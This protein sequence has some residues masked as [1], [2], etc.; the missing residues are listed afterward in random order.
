MA[1]LLVK[2]AFEI[3]HRGFVIAG[4][5]S[6][7]EIRPGMEVQHPNGQTFEIKSVE[8]FDVDRANRIAY[9]AAVLSSEAVTRA[10]LASMTL[11]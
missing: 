10:S 4:D 2:A 6:D 3:T 11:G 5:V 9:P 1:K 7:G 8:F